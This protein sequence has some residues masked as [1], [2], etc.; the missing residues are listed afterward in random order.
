[1]LQPAPIRPASPISSVENALKLLV[2]L[3]DREE[4]RVSEASAELGVARSTAHRLLAML[5][6]YGLVQQSANRAYCVGPVLTE[7]GLSALR[8]VDLREQMRPFLE[9]VVAELGETA[10][11]LVRDGANCRFID[12][13]EGTHALRTTAR[14]GISYPAAA[15]AGGKILLAQLDEAELLELYPSEQLPVYNRKPFRTRTEL[16]AH[17]AECRRR[18]YALNWGETEEGIFA[19]GV[20]QRTSSDRVAGALV[21]SAPEVRLGEDRI[22]EVAAVLRDIAADAQRR[23]P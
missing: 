17:L 12:C 15:A 16:F 10:H 19:V 20:L 9:R 13:L 11:L 21:V 7:I 22:D 18:N 2:I 8:Q 23:L 5:H 14:I 4:I 6:S 1:M 3:R